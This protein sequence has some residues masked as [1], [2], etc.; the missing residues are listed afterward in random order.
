LFD[1]S[2]TDSINERLQHIINQKRVEGRRM[3]GHPIKYAVESAQILTG[4]KKLNREEMAHLL[5]QTARVSKKLHFGE[6]QKT[7]LDFQLQE[8]LKFLFRFT[9]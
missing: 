5:N 9:V 1:E 3:P 6:F 8:H 7:L 2:D 4:S